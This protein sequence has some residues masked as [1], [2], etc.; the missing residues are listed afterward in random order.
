MAGIPAI[1]E[2]QIRQTQQGVIIDVV[3]GGYLDKA[4]LR[5]AVRHGLTRCGS[6]CGAVSPTPPPRLA[7]CGGRDVE[8]LGEVGH[9]PEPGGVVL[10]RHPA[11]AGPARRPGRGSAGGHRAVVRFHA[12]EVVVAHPGIVSWRCF[13][14]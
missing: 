11:L 2:Y 1:T 13:K 4:A 12:Q 14:G 9:E 8:G 10:D 5:D 3:A 7:H 6:G